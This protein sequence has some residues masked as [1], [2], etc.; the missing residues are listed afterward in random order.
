[1]PTQ[2]RRFEQDIFSLLNKKNVSMG[3]ILTF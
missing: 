1:M 2:F 3:D